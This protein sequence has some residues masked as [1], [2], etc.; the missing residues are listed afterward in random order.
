[1]ILNLNE[2]RLKHISKPFG[3]SSILQY[4]NAL[5]ISLLD[6]LDSFVRGY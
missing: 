6:R 4:D 1:M 2:R 3:D 5:N